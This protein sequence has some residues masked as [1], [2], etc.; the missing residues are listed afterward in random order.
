MNRPWRERRFQLGG[1]TARLESMH[2]A[3]RDRR[4]AS[5]APL[6][7]VNLAA[8]RLDT[9]QHS[10]G[11]PKA[12]RRQC[13]GWGERRSAWHTDYFGVHIARSRQQDQIC[14]AF[15]TKSR[16]VLPR[17]RAQANLTNI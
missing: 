14:I 7:I 13:E 9:R 15:R 2:S 17:N 5:A 10:A 16:S 8:G 11:Q 4:H 6:E 1:N 12:D 3:M